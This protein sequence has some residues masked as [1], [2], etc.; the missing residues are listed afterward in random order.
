MSER[1]PLLYTKARNNKQCNYTRNYRPGFQNGQF[2]SHPRK[3]PSQ[4][5]ID[6]RLPPPNTY[7]QHP[8][9][10]FSDDYTVHSVLLLPPS[11][12]IL[13]SLLCRARTVRAAT[14]H[15]PPEDIVEQAIT[16]S[17]TLR[18]ISNGPSGEI[19]LLEKCQE[20]VLACLLPEL[21][22]GW[23]LLGIGTD[24]SQGKLFM[25]HSYGFEPERGVENGAMGPFQWKTQRGS[26]EERTDHE[27]S[28]AGQGGRQESIRIHS[29]K[30]LEWKSLRG[31][32]ILNKWKWFWARTCDGSR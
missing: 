4:P 8:I 28:V 24:K 3:R 5:E 25:R 6:G 18:H 31:I 1:C 11:S 2:T 29:S 9:L 19:W 32:K 26:G 17:K 14:A 15:I 23:E 7:P 12:S 27:I 21:E 10:L 20:E 30:T 22:E 13:S 16:R